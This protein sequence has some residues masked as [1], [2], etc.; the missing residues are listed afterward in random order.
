[1]KANGNNYTKKL[2]VSAMLA[3][4]SFVLMYIG[5]LSG[6]FD[7]C[8][9]TLGA[10]GCAFAV[11]EMQGLWPWLVAGVTSVLCLILLPDKFAALEYVV[12]GGVYPIVK[13][14]CERLPKVYS[15]I[16]KLVYFNVLLTG[17]LFVAKYV[18]VIQE[19]WLALNVAAYAFANVF[20]VIFDIALT[21][22]VSLYLVRFRKRF[23]FKI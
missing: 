1:M 13:S 17:C 16:V 5:A 10:L 11:I 9:V 19:E 8:A 6:V 18:F 21:M 4:L 2:A 20:F 23:K 3:A 15:W 14:Y 7:L 22:F 12:L